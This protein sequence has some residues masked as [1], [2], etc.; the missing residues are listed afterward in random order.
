[1]YYN[2]ECHITIYQR[3]YISYDVYACYI[4]YVYEHVLNDASYKQM[5]CAT[6]KAKRSPGE[7]HSKPLR[8]TAWPQIMCTKLNRCL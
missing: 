3:Y 2:I 8:R 5:P 7:G 1:M 4:L 6:T